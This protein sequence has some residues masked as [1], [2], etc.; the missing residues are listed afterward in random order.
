MTNPGTIKLKQIMIVKV[1]TWKNS[2]Y[3]IFKFAQVFLKNLCKKF[4]FIIIIIQWDYLIS[5]KRK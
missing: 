4:I 2:G 1:Q 5:Q 3:R